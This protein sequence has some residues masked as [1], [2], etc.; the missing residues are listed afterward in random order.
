[1]CGFRHAESWHQTRCCNTDG[2][3]LKK[4]QG[5]P[6]G[7]RRS[8]HTGPPES[9]LRAVAPTGENGEQIREPDEAVGIDIACTPR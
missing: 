8:N 9:L 7:L 6:S 1:M 5:D 2:V 4:P 3:A